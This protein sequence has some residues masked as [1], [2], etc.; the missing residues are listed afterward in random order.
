MAY[1]YCFEDR[2]GDEFTEWKN[3]FEKDEELKDFIEE[4][5]ELLKYDDNIVK[6]L[7]SEKVYYE[8]IDFVQSKWDEM[9]VKTE[10]KLIDEIR[11]VYFRKDIIGEKRNLTEEQQEM[12]SKYFCGINC[13]DIVWNMTGEA[14]EIFEKTFYRYNYIRLWGNVYFYFYKDYLINSLFL[15]NIASFNSP[16]IDYVTNCKVD[17]ALSMQKEILYLLYNNSKI[18]TNLRREIKY[19]IEQEQYYYEEKKDGKINGKINRIILKMKKGENLQNIYKLDKR[20]SQEYQVRLQESTELHSLLYENKSRDKTFEKLGTRVSEFQKDINYYEAYM[21][22]YVTGVF[23]AWKVYDICF[24]ILKLSEKFDE[25]IET[26]VYDFAYNIGRIHNLEFKLYL[27]NNIEKDIQ[28][29]KKDGYVSLQE[30]ISSIANKV[31]DIA[32]EFNAKYDKMYSAMLYAFKDEKYWEGL[33]WCKNCENTNFGKLMKEIE[34][35]Q[36]Q[37]MHIQKQDIYEDLL[38]KSNKSV[39]YKWYKNIRENLSKNYM[40]IF[41]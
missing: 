29:I 41:E 6:K 27:L 2:F 14:K 40:W 15:F 21:V 17:M 36:K 3:N 31:G 12:I 5:D 28:A 38:R 8:F 20:L 37:E 23:T 16:I 18:T 22:E 30:G 39:E 1:K 4:R 7:F 13:A 10:Q 33:E 11:Q 32:T 9:E 19:D 35:L 25:K 34:L 26:E 24:E